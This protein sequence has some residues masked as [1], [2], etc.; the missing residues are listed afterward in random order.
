MGMLT[1]RPV[2]VRMVPSA[3]ASFLVWFRNLKGVRADRSKNSGSTRIPVGLGLSGLIKPTFFLLTFI[4]VADEDAYAFWLR[5][6]M[7]IDGLL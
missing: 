4:E 1:K 5:R 3:S 2:P 7:F 6:P